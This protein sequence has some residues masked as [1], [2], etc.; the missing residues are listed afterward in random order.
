MNRL[1]YDDVRLTR[2]TLTGRLVGLLFADQ[3]AALLLDAGNPLAAADGV[4]LS[5]DKSNG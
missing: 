5:A 4:E 1:P 2:R 3:G